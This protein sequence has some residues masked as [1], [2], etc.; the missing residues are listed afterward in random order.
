MLQRTKWATIGFWA[1]IVSA[2]ALGFWAVLLMRAWFAAQSVIAE[3]R[4]EAAY[5]VAAIVG[6]IVI[7]ALA[8]VQVTP[9]RWLREI[10]QAHTVRKLELEQRGELAIVRAR[11]LWAEQKALIGY[12][13]LLPA[14]Q[15]EVRETMKGLLMGIADTQRSIARTMGIQGDLARSIMGDAEI[16]DTLSYVAEQ[17]ERPAA[18][19][20]RALTYFDGPDRENGQFV[21][22]T[23]EP[24]HVDTRL[25]SSIPREPPDAARRQATPHDD[26]Y[27]RAARA[28]FGVKPW[29]VKQLAAKLD[30]S[31]TSA[32]GL[33]DDWQARG[34]VCETN[35]GRWSFTESGE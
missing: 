21:R 26:A 6:F 17:L 22:F 31:D 19:I 25:Q 4:I 32:R 13:R 11:L 29:R 1:I 16:A 34:W 12:A 15:Q 23:P 18:S 33:K 20:D 7:P 8:W 35:L 14:E 28:A 5:V 9:E 10:E 3:A 2:V 24:A 30:I 27:A